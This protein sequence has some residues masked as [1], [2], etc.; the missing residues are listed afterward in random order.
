M[1]R[2]MKYYT[3]EIGK[4]LGIV[5]FSFSIVVVMILLKYKPVFAVELNGEKL[6]YVSNKEQI[7]SSIEDY[8]NYRGD[9]IAFIDIEELPTYEFKLL[10]N[11]IDT[12]EE[13]VLLGV[14]ESSIITYVSYAIKLDGETKKEVRT[15]EEAEEV[16]NNIKEEY[17]DKIDLDLTIEEVYESEDPNDGFVEKEVAKTEISSILD[18]RIKAK[19]EEEAKKKAEEEKAKKAA[20]AKKAALAKANTQSSSSTSTQTTSQSLGITLSYPI[21]GGKVSSRFGSRSSVRSSAHT[22]LDLSAPYGTPIHPVSNGTVTFAGTKGSY[23][24]LIIISHGN[25][26]ETWY[27]HCSSINVSAGQSVTTSTTIGAVGS[28]GNSTGNHLH[29]EIRKDGTPLNPQNYLY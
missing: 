14:Q 13:E 23:G 28:T 16:V 6:G 8:K 2:R 15:L 19:E 25:G 10:N 18:D 26:V 4:A 24:K 1:I 11:K 12:N 7:E 20:A 17:K 21:S 27:G 29:L 22:G 9:N 5:L 3:K